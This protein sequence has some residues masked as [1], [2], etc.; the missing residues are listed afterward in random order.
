MLEFERKGEKQSRY[1]LLPILSTF[2]KENPPRLD[3]AL[4]LIKDDALKASSAKA[5]KNPLFSENAQSSI[6]YLAF[7]AEY[8]LLPDL[9]SIFQPLLLSSYSIQSEHGWL[10][11]LLFETS[12]VYSLYIFS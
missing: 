2:A 9:S 11:Q 6:K 3:E 5:S 4:N 12:A 8:E 1:Y 7:L 10:L